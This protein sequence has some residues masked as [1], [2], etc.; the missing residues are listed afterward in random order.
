MV[1]FFLF[2]FLYKL[3]TYENELYQYDVFCVCIEDE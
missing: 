2:V 1:Y 3:Y